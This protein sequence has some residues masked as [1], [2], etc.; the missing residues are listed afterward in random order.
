VF[1][2]LANKK[3]R[4]SKDFVTF[5]LDPTSWPPQ[6]AHWLDPAKNSLDSAKIVL[7]RATRFLDLAKIELYYKTSTSLG[8]W[9]AHLLN[10]RLLD[11]FSGPVL[12]RF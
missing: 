6:A 3:A 4:S 2:D 10:L 1:A 11:W 5:L 7:D 12:G 9:D 8:Q